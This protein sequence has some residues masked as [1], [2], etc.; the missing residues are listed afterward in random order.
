MKDA[1]ADLIL[2]AFLHFQEEVEYFG[3]HVIPLVRELE[4]RREPTKVAA[5]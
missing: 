2:L 1:G 3:R 5:E 4:A